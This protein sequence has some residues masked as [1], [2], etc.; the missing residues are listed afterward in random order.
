MPVTRLR[1]TLLVRLVAL[2]GLIAV[3]VVALFG[4]SLRAA[5]HLEAAAD[6]AH[7]SAAVLAQTGQARTFVGELRAERLERA[8]TGDPTAARQAGAAAGGAGRA[9]AELHALVADNPPQQRAVAAL[10]R[11]LDAHLRGTRPD[12][13]RR[14]A[15]G[16]ADFVAV[17]RRLAAQ[18]DAREASAA[19]TADRVA[20]VG[21]AGALACVLGLVALVVRTVVVP[22]RR[23]TAAAVTY[24]GGARETRVD[25][26]GPGE[27]GALARA[28]NDLARTLEASE[29]E[30][31]DRE[32]QYRAVVE[33]VGE[34]VFRIDA[35]GRWALLNPAWERLTG[36]PVADA[37]GVRAFDLVHPDD[38]A[39]AA[40]L[41]GELRAG[42][43]LTFEHR[44]LD[45]AGE[46]RWASVR[47]RR[48]GADGALTGLIADVTA[49]RAAAE[50]A[51]EHARSVQAVAEVARVL[52]TDGDVRGAIAAA[53]AQVSGAAHVALVERDGDDLVSTAVLGPDLPA[54]RLGPDEPSGCRRALTTGAPVFVADARADDAGVAT[55]LVAATGTRSALYQPILRDG[56][57]DAVLL[58]A[59][60]ERVPALSEQRAAVIGLL[61]L[62]AAAAL[63]RADAVRAAQVR[64]DT[65]ALTGLPNRRAWDRAIAGRLAE[66][67]AA[68]RRLTVALVDLDHFK[69]FND[70]HGHQAGDRLLRGAAA[71]WRSELR[72][73]DVLARYGGEEFALV[74]PDCGVEDAVGLA[75]R[76]RAAV[77]GDTTCSIGVAEWDGDED[78]EALLARADAALYRAK[79]TGRDRVARAAGAD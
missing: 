43:E 35:D 20:A 36:I 6:W 13:D 65:D 14:L 68:G 1:H 54:F 19:A 38:R 49:R 51:R 56:E 60:R 42:E 22:V 77:P 34:V 7:H 45:A 37:L 11:D 73:T 10:Q 5:E 28:F 55:G 67:R 53:A 4:A 58:V 9:L 46:V 24:T 74:A 29:R 15:R 78:A 31:R 71:A 18:R 33:G 40:L 76:L 79:R 57:A 59:W 62:E 72:G 44:Y 12:A 27:I 48:A 64:A 63:N 3:L 69:R 70:E 75:E 26:S 39:G 30:L 16:F 66:A 25:D 32:E 61:A 17:E 2:G 41:L 21:I 50:A 23:L 8:L 52:P 47:A